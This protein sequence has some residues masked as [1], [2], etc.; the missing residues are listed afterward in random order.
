MPPFTALA[1]TALVERTLAGDRACFDV[2]IER[3]TK[4][5]RAQIRSMVPNASDTDDLVQETFFKAWRRLETFRAEAAFRTWL[6]RV[7]INEVLQHHRS[8]RRAPIE[9][10]S[11]FL[12]NRASADQSPLDVATHAEVRRSMLQ[13]IAGLPAKYRCVLMMCDFEEI[14]LREAALRLQSGVPMVKS[15]L[16]RAR[17][18]VCRSVQAHSSV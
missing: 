13:S 14:P 5:V 1:D 16:F 2:L 3:H 10:F 7:A 9:A 12:E 11:P 4:A 18:M 17:R 15:R 8:I 6:I